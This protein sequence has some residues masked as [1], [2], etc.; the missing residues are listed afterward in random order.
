MSIQN[1]HKVWSRNPELLES[2]KEKAHTYKDEWIDFKI[3]LLKQID[4][5]WRK[6]GQPFPDSFFKQIH[7]FMEEKTFHN[8]AEIPMSNSDEGSLELIFIV[9][10]LV[11]IYIEEEEEDGKA[12]TLAKLEQG[13]MIGQYSVLF[14][15]EL[16]FKA[17]C[18]SVVR[19]LTIPKE[20]F[21]IFMPQKNSKHNQDCIKGLD[22]AIE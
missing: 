18:K 5:F 11:E 21:Q 15:E 7:F 16:A 4:Y 2:F 14:G 6:D 19:V 1:F 17:K 12:L 8:G 20:F 10:G 9:N 3:I 13:G 22:K